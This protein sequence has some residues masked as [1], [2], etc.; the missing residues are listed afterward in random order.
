MHCLIMLIWGGGEFYINSNL[1]FFIEICRD[2]RIK[3]IGGDNIEGLLVS[4][5]QLPFKYLEVCMS[6]I[7]I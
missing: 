5:K 1:L 2:G 6:F 3:I 7:L 4:P